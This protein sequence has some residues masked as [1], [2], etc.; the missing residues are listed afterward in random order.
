MSFILHDS[1][2]NNVSGLPILFAPVVVGPR[3]YIG[4]GA[5]VMCGV[6][7]GERAI[8]GAGSVVARDVPP[9]TVVAGNPARVIASL[10]EYEQKILR[11]SRSPREHEFWWDTVP[12]RERKETA[13]SYQPVAAWKERIR[14]KL[15]VKG[16]QS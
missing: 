5:I 2:A 14:A 13:E 8:V 3:S 1:A 15:G 4:V 6:T 10:E 9:R 12:W 7:I 16:A 11:R